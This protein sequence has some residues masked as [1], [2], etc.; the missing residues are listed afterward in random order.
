[1]SGHSDV[2]KLQLWNIPELRESFTSRSVEVKLKKQFSKLLKV[3][4][5]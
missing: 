5:F 2:P 4:L 3:F 1:M